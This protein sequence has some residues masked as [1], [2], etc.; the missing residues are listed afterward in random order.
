[1]ANSAPPVRKG[2]RWSPSMAPRLRKCSGGP[3]NPLFQP[4]KFGGATGPPSPHIQFF[5]SPGKYLGTTI[6]QATDANL[7]SSRVEPGPYNQHPYRGGLRMGHT[8]RAVTNTGPPLRRQGAHSAPGHVSTVFLFGG[9]G[10][11]SAPG[12][13]TFAIRG[14]GEESRQGPAQN[15]ISA[16]PPHPPSL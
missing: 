15:I 9:G 13:P 8:A 3:W 4:P 2:G 16:I 12:T 5:I 1:M 7:F 14:W 6:S 11:R 10:G